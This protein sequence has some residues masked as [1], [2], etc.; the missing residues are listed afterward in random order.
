MSSKKKTAKLP[1]ATE[2][3]ARPKPP[4][5]PWDAIGWIRLIRDWQHDWQHPG[6]LDL[7]W[8]SNRLMMAIVPQGWIKYRSGSQVSMNEQQDIG[9]G[10]AAFF[11]LFTA[12]AFE[13]FAAIMAADFR[14]LKMQLVRAI[15]WGKH[16][17]FS[18]F[19]QAWDMMRECRASKEPLLFANVRRHEFFALVAMLEDPRPTYA[20]AELR[21]MIA[22]RF[23]TESLTPKA[24]D[25]V[26]V[27]LG[28][29]KPKRGK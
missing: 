10:H 23:P 1:H 8:F 15:T 4:A 3:P 20:V 13:S 16:K 21:K 12:G 6:G 11:E 5:D 17:F 29:A 24:L 19:Q 28:I 9:Y 25:K 26:M 7:E 27:R 18:D 2:Q 14:P 22:R